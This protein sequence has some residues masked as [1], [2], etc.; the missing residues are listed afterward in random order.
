MIRTGYFDFSVSPDTSFARPDFNSELISN[1]VF[2]AVLVLDALKTL[3]ELTPDY[4]SGLAALAAFSELVGTTI[5]KV[6]PVLA[7]T[8]QS[9]ST[10]YK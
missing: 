3:S 5:G 2:N 4:K 10:F 7:F 9:L 6:V 1:S 8:S